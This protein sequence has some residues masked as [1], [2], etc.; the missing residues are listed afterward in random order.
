MTV[1]SVTQW[2]VR[3][4]KM[5]EFLEN[6]VRAKAIQERLGA[7]SVRMFMNTF[8]GPNAGMVTYAIEHENAE[9]Q[10]AF[11]D[12]MNADPEW[13]EFWQGVNNDN[14]SADMISN[15]QLSEVAFG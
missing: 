11:S 12:K 5:Q 7:Q 3:P 4:G 13:L 15:S 6:C 2:K 8:A 10:G 9:S 1:M 14:P